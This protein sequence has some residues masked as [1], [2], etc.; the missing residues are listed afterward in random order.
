MAMSQELLDMTL[1][2]PWDVQFPP[3]KEPLKPRETHVPVTG[4]PHVLPTQGTGVSKRHL[5]TQSSRVSY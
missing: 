5:N 4:F 3:D 2:G 1:K